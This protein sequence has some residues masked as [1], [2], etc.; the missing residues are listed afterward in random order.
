MSDYSDEDFDVEDLEENMAIDLISKIKEQIEDRS[1]TE[2]DFKRMWQ[3]Y[4]DEDLTDFEFVEAFKVY[5]FLVRLSV[6]SNYQ[7]FC[8]LV[9]RIDQLK[10]QDGT[11][12]WKTL[13]SNL[14]NKNLTWWKNKIKN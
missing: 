14:K 4:F 7:E 6:D 3:G 5:A 11:I 8:S 2:R 9:I 10:F 13:F 12:D 1:I